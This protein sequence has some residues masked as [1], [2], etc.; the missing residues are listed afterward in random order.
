MVPHEVP[1]MRRLAFFSGFLIAG[2]ALSL[3]KIPYARLA[4]QLA[5]GELDGRPVEIAEFTSVPF[6]EPT[7]RVRCGDLVFEVPVRARVDYK[8]SGDLVGVC[9]EL[10]GLICGT[11]PPR[12]E[13]PGDTPNS[14]KWGGVGTG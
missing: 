12:E 4:S 13:P 14:L 7:T 5:S 1:I 6:G 2:L 11:A 3:A 8:H 9:V 10:D